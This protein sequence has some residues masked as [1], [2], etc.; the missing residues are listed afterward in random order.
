MVWLIYNLVWAIECLVILLCIHTVNGKKIPYNPRVF[1]MLGLNMLMYNLYFS[2]ILS[3]LCADI[4]VAVGLFIYSFCSLRKG[5][6]EVILKYTGGMLLA[7]VI[8]IVAIFLVSFAEKALDMPAL[9]ALVN[10][11]I[12][13]GIACFINRLYY[14]MS[15]KVYYTVKDKII[16]SVKFVCIVFLCGIVADFI[17]YNDMNRFFN[18]VSFLFFIMIYA[19]LSVLKKRRW[20]LEVKNREIEIQQLYEAH[21]KELI[22]E[23]RRKQHDYKNQLAAIYS[24][25]Q[26][27]D[28]S[29]QLIEYT[30]EIADKFKYEKLLTYCNQSILSGFLYQKCLAFDKEDISVEYDIRVD[31]AQCVMPLH[32]IIEALGILLDNAFEHLQMNSEYQPSIFLKIREE[33]KQLCMEVKNQAEYLSCDNVEKLFV[34]GYS[35]KGEGRGIGLYRIRQLT[36]SYQAEIMVQNEKCKDGNRLCFRIAINK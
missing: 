2:G 31:K 24:M 6:W 10:S 19:L 22:K 32:E 15:K 12:M 16:V 1:F 35:T 29:G 21:Y 9:I 30:K 17:A 27:L 8:E 20:E 33:E 11:I 28:N 3:K 23:V 13:L 4:V 36:A 14:M 26:E 25:K 7:V 34:E 18:L 5:I